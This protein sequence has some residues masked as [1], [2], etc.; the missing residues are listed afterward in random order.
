MLLCMYVCMYVVCI[1]ARKYVR[2]SICMY[3]ICM[4]ECMY[5]CMYGDLEDARAISG[6]HY[7][8]GPQEEDLPQAEVLEYLLAQHHHLHTYIHILS[9]VRNAYVYVCAP[10]YSRLLVASRRCS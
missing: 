4:Y 2:M 8:I 1:C 9:H 7:S 3:I 6:A 5:E 10:A